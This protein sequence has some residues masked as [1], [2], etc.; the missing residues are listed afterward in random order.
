MKRLITRMR[1]VT[2]QIETLS[3]LNQA[4][5]EHRN[6]LNP[7]R[8]LDSPSLQELY[9]K[10]RKLQIKLRKVVPILFRLGRAH[11][12]SE[13]MDKLRRY[14]PRSFFQTLQTIANSKNS[15]QRALRFA[16]E[17]RNGLLIDSISINDYIRDLY[18]TD[19]VQV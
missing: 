8:D 4:V 13:L 5:N 19:V 11:I 7:V 18:S 16:A 15:S 10:K 9:L 2:T 3:V 12:V 14:V 6:D 1:N 17:R